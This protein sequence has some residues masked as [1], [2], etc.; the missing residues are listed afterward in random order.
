MVPSPEGQVESATMK[1]VTLRIVPFLMLCYFIAFVDRVNVGFAALQ[2]NKDIGLSA[3]AFGLGGG[4]FYITYVLFEVPSNLAMAKVGAKIWIAR[5]MVSWG[6]VSAGM[7]FI[8]GPY[9]FYAVRLLLGAAEAG[10]F[11]GVILYLTYWFPTEYRGR[12]VA[13]FMVAIPLS[14]FFGSPISASLLQLDGA[15]GFHGWQW[16]F[17]L[18]AVPAI[19]LGIVS[20]FFLADGPEAARWLSE[21]QRRWLSTRLTKEQSSPKARVGRLSLWQVFS[22]K[23][24]LAASLIY[25]GASGASQCLSLWQPQIIKSFGLT[26]LQTGLLN[27][28]PFGIASVLMLLWGRNSDRTGERK[29]H[30]AIP[31]ALLAA[32]LAMAGLAG[33]LAPTIA[34]LCVAVTATYIMK[35]PFWALSTEWMS[36]GVAAAAIAQIN[37][38][39]N[40]GGFFGSYL[41]GTIKDATGSFALGLLPLAGLSAVGFLLV[42]SL[43]RQQAPSGA[44]AATA[45]H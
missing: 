39:G 24:V 11:P 40:L 44:T 26:D 4:L 41:L 1:Q 35:G 43:S 45:V 33:A 2:M 10:F 29:W 17:V 7:A 14:S 27:S 23:Y 38:I 34:I 31:L 13:L 18:E 6:L 9:S 28:I 5:I 30:T 12:I 8:V 42:L 25:A 16:M 20:F 36:A 22:N 21:E 32:S 37:A 3:A 15:F 19:L